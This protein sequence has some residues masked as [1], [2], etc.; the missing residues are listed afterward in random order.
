M[1][2]LG[3][4]ARVF[5]QQVETPF[6]RFLRNLADAKLYQNWRKANPGEAARFDACVA[7]GPIPQMITPFGRALVAVVE[8]ERQP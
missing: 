8:M 2:N 6:Q 4:F 7:G 3:F 5:T 1:M